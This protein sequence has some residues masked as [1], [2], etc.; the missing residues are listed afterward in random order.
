MTKIEWADESWNPIRARN[1]E[2]GGTG[3]FC[4]AERRRQVDEEGWTAEHDDGHDD[5][6]MATAAS[7]Y[8]HYAASDGQHRAAM[9][10]AEAD[11]CPVLWPWSRVWWK[12]KNRRRDL[13][14]AAALIV[15]EIERLDRLTESGT[16]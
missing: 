6:E 14:R 9:Q 15:A 1:R 3:H 10:Y 12:P 5:G 8:A 7:T 4:V 16:H 11:S 2:T 13:V